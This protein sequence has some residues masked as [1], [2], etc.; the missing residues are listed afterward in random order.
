MEDFKSL[1]E[2]TQMDSKHLAMG[3]LCGSV[4]CLQSMHQILS[5]ETLND[6]VPNAIKGQFNV[7][8]NM[9][10]YSYYFYA[11]APEVHLKTYRIIEQALVLRMPNSKRMTLKDRLE[12]TIENGWIADAGFRH[13]NKTSAN[14]AGC[15]ELVDA[16]RALRNSQAHGS[17]MLVGDCIYHI[18]VCA[19]FLNQLFPDDGQ[20]NH[21]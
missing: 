6:A 7:A 4:P 20:F 17:L 9:A 19:D 1:A 21:Q 11:L 3:K 16:M 12:L 5:E 13:M 15:K 10:M 2:L 8:K 14:D 18:K